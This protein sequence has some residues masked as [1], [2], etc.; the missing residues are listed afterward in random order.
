MYCTKVNGRLVCT[1]SV[2]LALFF[3]A[4][5]DKVAG[6]SAEDTALQQA[7]LDDV[8]IAG[9]ADNTVL[10]MVNARFEDSSTVFQNYNVR[11]AVKKGTIVTAFELDSVTLDTTGRFF[12][13]TVYNDSGSFAFK[14]L[15]LNS[16]YVLIRVQDSCFSSKDDERLYGE[17]KKIHLDVC[18]NLSAIA[19]VRASNNIGINLL[20]HIKSFKLQ[21]LAQTGVSFATA[22]KQAE[23]EILESYGVY[24]NLEN[25]ESLNDKERSELSFVNQLAAEQ[26]IEFMALDT[27]TCYW[28]V[29]NLYGLGKYVDDFASYQQFDSTLTGFTDWMRQMFPELFSDKSNL[30]FNLSAILGNVVNY[31]NV[32]LKAV[33]SNEETLQLYTETLKMLDYKINYLAKRLDLGRCTSQREGDMET[34]RDFHFVC[35]SGKWQYGYRWMDHSNGTMVDERDGKTYRTVT[36]NIGGKT[37]T[38]MADNLNFDGT[39]LSTDSELRA[40][41]KGSSNCFTGEKSSCDINGRMYEWRAAMNFADDSLKVFMKDSAE[42][43][44]LDKKCRHLFDDYGRCRLDKTGEC[45]RSYYKVQDMCNNLYGGKSWI[46]FWDW[47]YKELM[48]GSD[49]SNYQ[50]VCPDGWRLPTA[51]DWRNLAQFVVNQYGADSM[52]AQ[53][54]L[55]DEEATGFGAKKV[56][57]VENRLGKLKVRVLT[58]PSY[59][60]VPDFETMPHTFTFDDLI[61]ATHASIGISFE[62]EALQYLNVDGVP[63]YDYDFA[64]VPH[65]VRC[66]KD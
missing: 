19:D 45:D 25:F 5:C 35:R 26:P 27:N 1:L 10:R 62:S 30:D 16:P 13:D 64:Y 57:E 49:P 54:I 53:T 12:V 59:V 47:N 61:W 50:G 28:Y 42:M 63:N 31:R 40:N 29:L 14:N 37:Q 46:G 2:L 17:G 7:S 43:L 21:E 11:F 38:W 51:K 6:G 8:T 34:R 56:V 22:N 48:A 3:A 23:K 52:D 65:W 58:D 32:P 55:F 60:A 41:L 9:T 20:T 39:A 4:C 33:S 15:S 36:Y 24:E 18:R 66:I 44:L